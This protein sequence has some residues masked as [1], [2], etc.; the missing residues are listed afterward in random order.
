MN[1]PTTKQLKKLLSARLRYEQLKYEI[2]YPNHSLRR[3]IFYSY[4]NGAAPLTALLDL[5]EK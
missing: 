4:P 5:L 2:L 1:I 3:R